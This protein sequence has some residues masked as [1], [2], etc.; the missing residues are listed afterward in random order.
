DFDRR[1]LC[2][3]LRDA[4][5]SIPAA[6]RR[7][8]VL[9][10]WHGLSAG[11]VAAQLGMNQPATYAL[12]TRA[13]RSLTHAFTALPQRAALTLASIVYDLRSHVKT[14]LGG[15]ATKAAATTTVVAAVV[16]TGAS[17]PTRDTENSGSRPQ[18]G[19]AALTNAGAAAGA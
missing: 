17:A 5:A 15:A 16:V 12:L 11:D 4:L 2:H 19:E 14:L 18:T 8:L 3:D 7:A 13:R 9:R 10:E 6:Q 1:E